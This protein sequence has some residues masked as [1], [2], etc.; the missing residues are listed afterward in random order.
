[1]PREL[2]VMTL[3]MIVTNTAGAMYYPLLPLYLEELGADV[4]QVG[5]FF[6]LQVILG[7]CFR[8][9]GGWISDHSGRLPT[10]A[11]GGVLGQVAMLAFT[12][13]PA[14]GWAMIGALFGQ[15]G[16]SL[17]APSFQAYT[18]EQAPEGST[19][20]TFGLVTG[21]F[22][23]CM[24]VG[25]LLGGFLA[26]RVG[27]RGMLWVANAIFGV[28]TLL[29]LWMVRGQSWAMR[30][31]DP[32]QLVHD[33]RGLLVMLFGG[34]VLLWLFVVDG[35]VD[36]GGQL[37]IPFLPKFATEAGGLNEATFG[38]LFAL[39]NLVGALAMLPG[40]MFADRFHERRSIA[41]G[42]ALISMAYWVILAHPVLITFLIGMCLA[43]IGQAF[44]G[45][46]FS[47][48]ISKA[49]PKESLGIT[50]G[51]FLTALGVLA[52]PAPAIGGLLYDR[53]APKATFVLAMGLALVSIP[54]ALWKLR[55][56]VAREAAVG[57]D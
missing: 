44:V 31:L 15:M 32:S 23:I 26:Y 12:V 9:L 55:L 29:R 30:E 57:A 54:L 10:I 37:A 48:L 7:I 46:A 42:M 50:W 13:A 16:S 41:V 17:V 52:I 43:G 49:V 38:G 36:A 14:W 18:A 5:F 33:V 4:Q 21:L 22:S 6:T 28:G 35:L 40:G 39:G 47:S 56:P 1:M 45:P 20:S 8:I 53:V 51:V 19:G 3:A 11:L 27:F 25:P 24:I 34:G 2:M